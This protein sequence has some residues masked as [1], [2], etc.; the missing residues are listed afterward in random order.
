MKYQ[1]ITTWFFAAMC[2]LLVSS[3][4]VQAQRLVLL[5][6][7]ESGE[8]QATSAADVTVDGYTITSAAGRLNPEAWTSL[9]DQGLDIWTEA[10]PKDT[11]LSE[12]TLESTTLAGGDAVS[13]GNAYT[14]GPTLPHQED[15]AF[16]YSAADGV[17]RDGTVVYQGD[18]PTPKLT[19][20][21]V[22]GQV[23][24]TNPGA[25]DVDGYSIS[26][27]S[28]LLL[29]DNLAAGE[30]FTAANPTATNIAG[31]NLGGAASFPTSIGLG[32]IFNT[33]A[34]APLA[35]EDLGLMYSTPDGNVATG[36][37]EYE[38][39]VNDL[40]LQVDLISGAARIS[41]MSPHVATTEITGYS[42]SS[43]SGSL[44]TAG[45]TGIG[46]GFS[47]ANPTADAIAELNPSGTKEFS[48]GT[49][50]DL[51]TILIGATDL[52]FE[53]STVSGANVGSVEYV[54][55][56]GTVSCADVK[57]MRVASGVDGDLNGDGTV[58]FTDFIVLSTN[59]GA[60][61][62]SYEEGDI[63]C[64][65]S[66]D[67]ADFI[68]LSTNFGNAVPQAA[69]VPEPSGLTLAGLSVLLGLCLRRRRS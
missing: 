8:L 34:G 44:G 37:V 57:A 40:T 10:N 23:T 12:L 64:G 41:H 20:S 14:G 50:A 2:G 61:V 68:V 66:V 18:L 60:A 46:D 30:G 16:Q 52:V 43:A 62:G 32:S 4:A 47:K 6:D 39:P 42:I 11:Q 15:L 25:F 5:V 51:G 19:V 3:G 31:L 26:S 59:F 55:G 27:P 1:Q 63:D 13:L 56:D 24:L 29:P 7:R 33:A 67:F 9:N 21:R 54:M 53:Y 49:S 17:L 48:N 58:G 69:S 28:G 65:G 22:T 45:F 38:G 35:A 36:I